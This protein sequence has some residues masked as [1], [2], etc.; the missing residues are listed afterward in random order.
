MPDNQILKRLTIYRE[1]V[2]PA[3]FGLDM[4]KL[5]V[6]GIERVVVTDQNGN[7]MT[8]RYG[9]VIEFREKH[10]MGLLIIRGWSDD[11]GAQV[12][13][14][15][16]GDY[17]Y[18]SGEIISDFSQLVSVDG[19]DKPAG[20]ILDP[21]HRKNAEAWW[22]AIGSEKSAKW[23]SERKAAQSRAIGDYQQNASEI[24]SKMDS[25]MYRR[26]PAGTKK[27]GK[28]LPI[29]WMS[30]S[31]YRRPDWWG[32][33][34]TISFPDFTYERVNPEAAETAKTEVQKQESL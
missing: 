25:A 28:D 31:F 20:L 9:P 26:Y 11:K 29:T 13:V 17:V 14:A 23:Y 19:K 3:L 10:D 30:A 34:Q 4:Q 1:P 7:P 2:T 21:I 32:Q 5:F 18:L 24:E 12:F 33:C 6:K 22:A 15:A 27:S 16:N 8:D